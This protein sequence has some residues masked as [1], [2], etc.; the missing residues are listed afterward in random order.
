MKLRLAILVGAC[1]ISALSAAAS[2]AAPAGGPGSRVPDRVVI[3]LRP[4]VQPTVAK[5]AGGVTVD[6]PALQA[7]ADRFGA[8]D[9][10]R[11]YEGVPPAKKA[12]LPDLSLVWAVDF[13][14]AV[15][16][17]AVLAAYAA[18][19]EVARAEAVDIC[20]QTALPNDPFLGS[21]WYLRN[22]TLGAKDI[23]AVG[24]WAEAQGDSNVII[25]IVDSG[26][27]WRHPDLGGS[28]PNYRRGAIWTNWPEANGVAGVDD[29]GNGKVDDSRGWDFVT[30]VTGEPGEDVSVPDNDPSDWESHGTACA[31]VAAAIT[32]N[33]VGISGASWGCKIM[34]VRVGWLQNGATTGVV[35]MDFASQG[36]I[37]AAANGAKFINCSWG[38]TEYLQTAADY[39]LAA[40]ALVITA[41]GNDANEVPS[42]LADYPGVI[43]VA[44]TDANDGKTSFSSY[45]T[46]VELS[47]P[48]TGIYTTWYV[49]SDGS[50]GYNT[51][52]GTSFSSPL[53]CGAAALIMSAEPGLTAL[54]VGT[55]LMSTADNIDALNPGLA[56]KLGSGRVNLLRALGDRLLKYP[57]EFSSLL[58]AQNEAAP[59]DTVALSA[60]S[61]LTGPLTVANKSFY[62]LG[63]Y[64]AD[65][66]SRDPV[67]TPTPLNASLSGSGLLFQTG[68]GLGTVVD[69]LLIS[70]GGGQV[71]SSP[72]TGRYGG[73]I[74]CN[75]TS[76]TLRNIEVTGNSVGGTSEF[77]GGGGI[78]LSNSSAL[79]ENVTVHGNSAVQGAGVYAYLG[80]PTLRDCRIYD[81]V[82]V[83]D[84]GSYPPRGGG[85]Y[86]TDTTLL[87]DGCEIS[88]HVDAEA[89]GGIYAANTLATTSLALVGN[90]IHHNTARVKGGGLAMSGNAITMLRDDL[91]DNGKAAGATFMVGGA[92]AV[93]NATVTLDSVL[94]RANTAQVGA[95]GAV[96][97]SPQS[98]VRHCVFSANAADIFGGGL[99]SQTVAAGEVRGNTF[100]A[101]TAGVGAAGLYLN[102]ASPGI[103]NNIF[104]L[105]TGGTTFG[106][107]V[108]AQSS[109]PT[110]TCNDAWSN[111]GTSY[112]GVADPTGTAG[113]I[114]LDPQF[115]FPADGGYGLKPL[116]PCEPAVSGACG[117][118]GALGVMCALVPVLDDPDLPALVFRV[119]NAAPNP[120]NPLTRIRFTLPAAGRVSVNVYDLAGRLV[121]V[122]VDAVLPAAAHETQWNGR[123]DAGHA[124]SSGV[125]FYRVTAGA[126]SY[127][128]R[129]ALVK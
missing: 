55:R 113:N 96:T 94:S 92:F 129:M 93:E 128:G 25:A 42:F 10:S 106:N 3:T 39:C 45:G 109:T 48:G 5:R 26:V 41:A 36:M 115:C 125:Y 69:G 43:A 121:R 80:A 44:A 7:L 84:N 90:R 32:N 47:A 118:I 14:T 87:L 33:G 13:A 30:G 127:T 105:N 82:L 51:V 76:P 2:P 114:A 1:A 78:M 9:M 100:A 54:G 73:G 88:G 65:F 99:S 23:R 49:A 85:I 53:T 123:D 97:S 8:H 117:L 116:S 22:L 19:P 107:A 104:A 35:R 108:H 28:G 111:T 70:G 38:S 110:F 83:Q 61:P 95:G 91:H 112:T 68:T 57:D 71:F 59:G 56:G 124:V 34:P 11:L 17:D 81:N 50:H 21:Q 66:A 20:A 31:G 98:D 86:A 52:A 74:I 12:G 6:R 46:W 126:D 119:E 77:G 16:L 63:G 27:D 37:Y 64:A 75:G 72:Q 102:A 120:F 89:G 101:N 122:L 40:G 79:L 4:G 29:D 18:L 60:A 58:D 24:G 15:D 67:G 62:L 103:A